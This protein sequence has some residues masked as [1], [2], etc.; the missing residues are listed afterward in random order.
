MRP[1]SGSQFRVKA[2]RCHLRRP[3]TLSHLVPHQPTLCLLLCL[4][5]LRLN[6]LSYALESQRR[7]DG[8]WCVD[9]RPVLETRQTCGTHYRDCRLATTAPGGADIPVCAGRQMPA[10]HCPAPLSFLRARP[11]TS[12][13]RPYRP[14]PTPQP[15]SRLAVDGTISTTIGACYRRYRHC[16]LPAYRLPA[17]CHCLLPAYRTPTA[18]LLPTATACAPCPHSWVL[19]VL[20]VQI[21]SSATEDDNEDERDQLQI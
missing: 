10:P 5:T 13:T 3:H 2:L 20:A 11:A 12:Q 1:L 14:Q 7:G 9:F 8:G 17:Y 15:P 16:L 18:C 21:T 19:G 4:F 6:T